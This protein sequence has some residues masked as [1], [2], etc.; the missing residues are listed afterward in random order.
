M[1]FIE[2]YFGFHGRIGRRT[3][4][5]ASIT[6]G[7][8]QAIVWVGY[9][10]LPIPPPMLAF[11]AGVAAFAMAMLNAKRLHDVGK[12]GWWQLIS[13]LGIPLI[14]G[15][16][17]AL[18]WNSPLVSLALS[19]SAMVTSLA[20]LWIVIQMWFF[21]GASGDN[22]FGPAPASKDIA[23]SLEQEISQL[24]PA[25][26]RLAL[27]NMP[28]PSGVIDRTS[29]SAARPSRNGGFGRRDSRIA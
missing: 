19:L 3:F 6:P 22:D 26:A 1:P 12:S 27:A 20:G 7:T 28:P 23:R 25:T 16:Y 15:A 13:L 24:Q 21:Q 11:A 2:L 10:R 17:L 5:L 14:I 29:R 8:V 9:E 4:W 18:F